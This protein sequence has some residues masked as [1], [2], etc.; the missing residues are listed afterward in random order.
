MDEA[1]D[2]GKNVLQHFH[3]LV[4]LQECDQEHEVLRSKGNR[5]ASLPQNTRCM[6]LVTLQLTKPLGLHILYY[7]CQPHHDLLDILLLSSL[8]Q[9][10]ASNDHFRE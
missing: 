10:W 6:H 5:R 1:T 3:R 4:R 9:L 7:N 2:E 8:L